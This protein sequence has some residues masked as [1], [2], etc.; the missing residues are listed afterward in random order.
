MLIYLDESGTSTRT[1][2]AGSS[3]TFSIALLVVQDPEPVNS[4]IRAFEKWIIGKGWPIGYEVKAS[5]IYAASKLSALPDAY[6]F[7]HD[8][9]VPLS[10][11]YDKIA[12]L[13]VEIDFITVNKACLTPALQSAAYG[14]VYNYFAGQ[15]LASR[16]Q[17]TNVCQLIVDAR[18]KE[19]HHGK[20]FDGYI[21]TRALELNSSISTF[22]VEHL[23]S[24][25]VRG[26]RAVD[27][28]S[29]AV[30]RNYER[31]DGRWL[32]RITAVVKNR[33]EWFK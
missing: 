5:R 16:L 14:I 24:C 25:N 4:V 28:A 2:Q 15:V 30:F 13:P 22:G 7:K 8:P 10:K 27:Y 18:S 23:D 21:Q 33:Q 3:K 19:V 9:L 6:E 12:T 32:K 11:I 17:S 29:W 20:H 26:L 1:A 31:G